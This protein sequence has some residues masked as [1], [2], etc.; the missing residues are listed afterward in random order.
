MKRRFRDAPQ[1]QRCTATITL[2]DKSEAQCGR[3]AKV[4]GLCRQHAIK[5]GVLVF[6]GHCDNYEQHSTQNC[7]L[8]V[9]N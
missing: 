4:K 1:Q 9:Y 3:Y 5:S 7:M 2:R 6:C 8:P